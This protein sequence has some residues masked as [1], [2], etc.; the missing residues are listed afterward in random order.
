MILNYLGRGF[1]VGGG[2]VLP[3]AIAG[4][5]GFGDVMPKVNLGYRG[6]RVNLTAYVVT[7]FEGVLQWGLVGASV[8]Y[9]F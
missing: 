6:E 8:G 9:R 2:A 3:V 7:A 1:F 5:V 4:G